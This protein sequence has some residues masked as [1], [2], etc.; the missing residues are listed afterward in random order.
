[1]KYYQLFLVAA[2]IAVTGC[3]NQ[4]EA[5][6]Q[7]KD[8]VDAV[9]GS[10]HIE[11]KDQYTVMANADGFLKTAYVVEGDTVKPGQKMFRLTNDVQQT[12]VG[13]ALT[14]LQFAK[15]NVSPRSPQ[16]DQ[17][18][19]QIVQAQAKLTVDSLNYT[20]YGRLVKTNAVSKTDFE[21]AQLQYQASLSSL[22]VLKKNL[23]DLQHNL[24]LSV[25]NAKAQYQIQQQNNDYYN[26]TGTTPG[27]VVSIAK[28]VGDY[29]KK[30][31]AIGVVGAGNPVVK[32][33]IAEDDIQRI[34]LGQTALI[35]LNSNKDKVYK[36]VITKIYPSFDTNQQ[37][38]TVDATFIDQPGQLI[39]G[40][41]LQGNVI[42]SEKKDA[43]VIPSYYLINGD[44]VFIK[45]NKEKV[46]VKA[47]IRTLEWT[48]IL[49]GLT[50]NDIV[51]Q[52]KQN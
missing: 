1:M 14:N 39:N 26:I 4:N 43:L 2:V 48:E 13:N 50:E 7:R 41:Q 3:K 18:K 16:I 52:P 47:G 45:N 11:N 15:T 29:V 10:G 28:K 23:A 31:D 44:Y 27:I 42:I 19:I 6:P 17:L 12:Q 37:A 36:S 40:T 34:K 38:F 49:S 25:E 32:L 33:Y 46:A 8:I 30:G 51:I 22:N 5:K 20:R 24:N 21:N 9:F 35:S